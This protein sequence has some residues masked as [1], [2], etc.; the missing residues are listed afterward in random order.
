MIARRPPM[1]VLSQSSRQTRA[2]SRSAHRI[3]IVDDDFG[4]R[5][6]LTTFLED[7]GYQCE[8]ARNGQDALMQLQGSDNPPCIILL[9]LN[10]PI[11]T[12]WQFMQEQQKDPA[13]AAVPV[14][15]LSADRRLMSQSPGIA[16]VE[17]F[18]KPLDLRRL[19]KLIE[20]LC[21]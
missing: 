1:K 19:L 12:G 18:N 4:I 21:C 3:L 14:V 6:M 9:D 5:G 10:M 20:Q 2:E 13:L 16:P 17:S 11:M 8:T 15:V 7:E